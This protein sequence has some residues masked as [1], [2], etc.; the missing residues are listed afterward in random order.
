MMT[1]PQKKMMNRRNAACSTGPRTGDGKSRSS[2]N[3]LKH[4]LGSLVPILPGE[5]V[6]EW[7]AYRGSIVHSLAPAPGFEQVLAERVAFCAW[8]LQRVARYEMAVTA[9][10]MQPASEAAPAPPDP[11]EGQPD[12]GAALHAQ[13]AEAERQL[14]E[15]QSGLAECGKTNFLETLPSL[16]P[17]A[18]VRAADVW[19]VCAELEDVA[20]DHLFACGRVCDFS[21]L[22]GLTA[23]AWLSKLGVPEDHL[24]DAFDHWTGWTGGMLRLAWHGIAAAVEVSPETL[25]AQ[26][27]AAWRQHLADAR[28]RVRACQQA[29]G[30]L[31]RQVEAWERLSRANAPA[32]R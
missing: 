23:P 2:Q 16:A 3:A 12:R 22:P 17:D 4:G 31:R 11:A 25:L 8:R 32:T 7:R 18:P 10:G 21:V 19:D 1:S 24:E 28:D 30:D 15:A 26:A 29:V 14:N 6:K 13:L 5:Q 20:Q 9:L 27:S